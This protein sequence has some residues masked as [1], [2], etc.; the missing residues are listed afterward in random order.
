MSGLVLGNFRFPQIL[1]LCNCIPAEKDVKRR[2]RKN[3]EENSNFLPSLAD[4]AGPNQRLYFAERLKYSFKN[5]VRGQSC[6][7]CH[8]KIEIE[9]VS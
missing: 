4:L 9:Y 2:I 5:Q 3:N 6:Y 8:R 7:N 1:V